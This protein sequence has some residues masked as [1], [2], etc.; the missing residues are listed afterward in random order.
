MIAYIT[1]QNLIQALNLDNN[2]TPCDKKSHSKHQT[3]ILAHAKGSGN[4]TVMTS[5]QAASYKLAQLDGRCGILSFHQTLMEG[6]QPWIRAWELFTRPFTCLHSHHFWSNYVLIAWLTLKT[7][8]L[9]IILIRLEWSPPW[10]KL[11]V[12]TSEIIWA[13]HA[14]SKVMHRLLCTIVWLFSVCPR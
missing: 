10:A 11:Y 6:M 7:L 5:W 12:T 9:L 3:L 14:V 1:L 2:P 13:T 4:V 8:D